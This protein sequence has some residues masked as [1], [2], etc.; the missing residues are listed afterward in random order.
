[1]KKN[2]KLP[3]L[4]LPIFLE[5]LSNH[6]WMV[7]ALTTIT[8]TLLLPLMLSL[9]NKVFQN[10][11]K[12]IFVGYSA[13]AARLILSSICT[14]LMTVIG[15]LFSIT[16]VVIQ[17]VSAQY[18]PRVVEIFIKS[19]N[20][21][22]VLGLYVG[23][24][25][26]GILLLRQIPSHEST[27]GFKI[28]QSAISLAIILA[29]ICISFLVQ[30]VHYITHAIKSTN[31]I[32]SII[33]EG[34]D[35]IEDYENFKN[36]HKDTKE[37]ENLSEMYE[38]KASAYGYFQ[39]YLPERIDSIIGKKN[40]AKVKLITH[41]GEYLDIG[42]VIAICESQGPLSDK[43]KKELNNTITIGPERTHTQDVRYSIRQLVDIALRA[44]SPGINDPSTAMEALNGVGVLLKLWIKQSDHSGVFLLK[45]ENQIII[46]QLTLDI[47][48]EQSFAQTIVAAKGHYQVLEKILQI[49]SEVRL[50]PLG[51]EEILLLDLYMKNVERDC[52]ESRP[53][54]VKNLNKL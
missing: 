24:F 8:I 39:S 35:Y 54:F 27:E 22:F 15:V 1:M 25:V 23:T 2:R 48:L 42:D 36:S 53:T 32:K 12:G 16:V 52:G 3:N 13:D 9:D 20:S 28:P 4:S 30:Y 49:L 18:S 11:S 41:V 46:P 26:Y 40:I 19:R 21:Q 43:L 17:Q 44:L 51:E 6:Y 29:L 31:I 38:L 45:C 14:A 50:L 5:K 33:D 7:P 37:Y 10:L 34:V 47:L